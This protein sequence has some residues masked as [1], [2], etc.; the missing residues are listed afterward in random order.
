MEAAALP[1]TPTPVVRDHEIFVNTA[2][3]LAAL[4]RRL[5]PCDTIA[6]DTEADSL[7]SY[8]EKLCLVQLSAPGIDAAIDPLAGFDL[9]PLIQILEPRRLILHGADF[10]LKMLQRIGEFNPV[11][12]FDTVVAARFV[13]LP[14]FSLAA[15]VKEFFGI[16]LAKGSQKANWGKRPLSDTM[17][18]YAYN[19]TRFLIEIAARL[20]ESLDQLE[21][22]AWAKQTSDKTVAQALNPNKSEPSKERWKIKGWASTRGRATIVLRAL[23]EWRELEAQAVDRPTFHILRNEDLLLS[24]KAIAENAPLPLQHV[25]GGRRRRLQEAA[26]A[27]MALPES[28]W[29]KHES[30]RGIRMTQ[31]E[32]RRADNLKA[33]RDKAAAELKL[34]PSLIA[35]RSTLEKIALNNAPDLLLPWQKAILFPKDTQPA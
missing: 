24:A 17:L 32:E 18:E 8:Y 23:W 25:S 12:V 3:G 27:A 30:T 34:D 19:D 14:E 13:G 21:R 28:E 31:E 6:V 35:S 29:P 4:I 20:Q 2:E 1:P 10:D 22:T 7:H 5:E 33:I 26:A 16:V 11:N 15:L 9:K